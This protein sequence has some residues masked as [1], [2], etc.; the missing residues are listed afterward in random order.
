MDFE[1]NEREP[2]LREEEEEETSFYQDADEN[3]D[4]LQRDAHEIELDRRQKG[5]DKMDKKID[6]IEKKLNTTIPP[7]ER[8]R[9]RMSREGQLEFEKSPGKYVNITRPNGRILASS[10]LIA[11]LGASLARQLFNIETPT[12]SKTVARKLL[13]APTELEMSEMSV[14]KILEITDTL[15]RDVATNTDLDMREFLG[16]DKALTR[17]KGELANNASKLSEIDEHISREQN[18]LTDIDKDPSLEVHRKK[19]TDRLKALKEER[20]ARLEITSQNEKEL[21]SQYSRIR[22]TAEKILDEDLGLREKIKLVFREHGLTI[23]AV[24]SSI[25][26]LISTI[27]TSLTGGTGA[28]GSPTPPKNP[29][30]LLEWFKSKLRA[31]GR[32]LGRLAGKAAA[33]L[34]GIIGAI[35]SGVLNFL[36]KVV[37]AASEHV[38]LLLT[39]M[40]SLIIY[41]LMYPPKSKK[42]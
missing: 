35:I 21:A 7:R 19:V 20:S 12:S 27:V 2:L 5:I 9:F 39:S 18:K 3:L 22:Q 1:L 28:S 4:D 26:L 25:G 37:V 32:V 15:G 30:K 29:N 16:I 34:P 31:L 41:R 42:R 13:K 38:W 40:A 10:T 6:E 8:A 23:T 14:V 17:I 24:L 36:K 33:A 11:K